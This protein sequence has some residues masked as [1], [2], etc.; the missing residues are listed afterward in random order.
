[1]PAIT[2]SQ[3]N[4]T[5]GDLRDPG[6]QVRRYAGDGRDERVERRRPERVR[7]L[8][9]VAAWLFVLVA[10]T[11]LRAIHLN[12]DTPASLSPKDRGEYVDE[13]YKTLG[14]RNELLF[15]ALRW[16][17]DDDYTYWR[18][19][20]LSQTAYAIA[21][22]VGNVDLVSARWVG[23]LAFF[24]MLGSFAWVHRRRSLLYLAGGLGVLSIAAPIFFMSRLALLEGP[25]SIF[26]LGA[27]LFLRAF[28]DTSTLRAAL[29]VIVLGAIGAFGVKGSAWVYIVPLLLGVGVSAWARGEFGRMRRGPA[30]TLV[31]GL[32]VLVSATAYVI[33]PR[34]LDS[35]VGFLKGVLVGP[36]MRLSWPWLCAAVASVA[37]LSVRDRVWLKDRYLA[38]LAAASLCVPVLIAAFDYH[39]LRYFFP[40]VP[41]LV[42]FVVE[43][44]A[45]LWHHQAE[46][47]SQRVLRLRWLV[48]VLTLQGVALDLQ[49]VGRFLLSPTYELATATRLVAAAIPPD[50]TLAG[51][52][53]P[54]F[55][56]GT[57]IKALYA[58]DNFNP[59]TKWDRLR[60]DYFLFSASEESYIILRGLAARPDVTVAPPI[61]TTSY[62]G[63]QVRLHPLHWHVAPANELS[64]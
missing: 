29:G 6:A 20:P 7:D 1:M 18:N 35:P 42:A 5:E 17:P 9:R 40:V 32:I 36:L 50:A 22:R 52:W 58:N 38:A 56:L 53:A 15:G 55:A 19:S 25:L 3:A 27:A 11:A 34:S 4:A 24:L 14:P 39:P 57:R 43:A 63:Y 10:L 49:R 60:P 54:L 12:A 46:V 21:F 31:G 61:V 8:I 51:D 16:Q 23:I 37:L 64:Q 44:V 13:G 47:A 45:S 26:V 59:T 33:G 2:R 30:L 62:V 48:V 41:L 28:P